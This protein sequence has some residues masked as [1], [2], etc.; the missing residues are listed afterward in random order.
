M[1][2]SSVLALRC[3]VKAWPE[4]CRRRVLKR[5]QAS[6]MALAVDI[7]DTSF[8]LSRWRR[9]LDWMRV[10]AR[11]TIMS[12]SS[13]RMLRKAWLST[14]LRRRGIRA[15][16][17]VSSG[18]PDGGRRHGFPALHKGPGEVGGGTWGS[19]PWATVGAAISEAVAMALASWFGSRGGAAGP[20][21][22]TVVVSTSLPRAPLPAHP[23]PERWSDGHLSPLC[24]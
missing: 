24:W 18:T 7:C 22:V 13:T 11:D 2:S 5:R 15:G 23:S 21:G 9:Q 3:G 20:V 10:A 4:R 16:T 19:G 1:F 14:T 8:C 6:W 17:S 12:I